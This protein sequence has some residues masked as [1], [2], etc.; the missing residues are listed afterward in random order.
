[1]ERKSKKKKRPLLAVLL[2]VLALIVLIPVALYAYLSYDHFHIGDMRAA[3]DPDAPYAGEAVYS[4]D[5]DVELPLKAED[6]YW[7]ADEY[8]LLDSLD[9]PTVECVNFAVD[10]GDDALTLY[11]DVRYLGFLPVPLKA[12][13]SVETSDALYVSIESVKIGKWIDVPVKTLEKYGVD[14]DYE[15]S[16][17]DL[18]E[19]TQIQS[20][21][22]EAGQFVVVVPFLND[23]SQY[24]KPD[25]TADTLLL[26]GADEDD[27]AVVSAST[28]YRT[29]SASEQ[30]RIV[31]EYVAAAKQPVEALTRL[32]ALCDA[33]AA[34]NAIEALDPVSAHFLLPASVSDIASCRETYIGTIADYNRMLE[35][36]LNTLR[37]KYKALEIELTRNAYVDA[38]TGETLSLSALCP[39]LGLTDEQCHPVLLIATEPLKAP[40]TADLPL[41]S[42][43]PKSRGLK[44]DMALD[45]MS[46]DIG[47]MLSMPDGST[48]MLYY[49]STGEMV[50]QCLPEAT[51]ESIFAQYRVPKLFNLD[52][53]VYAALRVK[54][55]APATDLSRYIVFLPWD[56]ETTW[57]AKNK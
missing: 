8:D 42:E 25:M 10:I 38:A 15:I 18:L 22:F 17:D 30:K 6:L 56:I 16:L 53:A 47:V 37:D 57:S 14:S 55:D 5:G 49:A 12:E 24:F 33:D 45:Y 29:E 3:C 19:D 34:A 31:R 35:T 4:A 32:L 41:F 40:S 11:A 46:Y 21:R 50:V 51:A 13:L 1:M 2:V 20:L 48:A 36:L 43:I 26:Y 39:Q 23:F 28:C 9:I 52:T 44:L 54:H 7:L 27:G